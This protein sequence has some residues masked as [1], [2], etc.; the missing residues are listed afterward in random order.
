M[1]TNIEEKKAKESGDITGSICPDLC[2]GTIVPL[3]EGGY[4]CQ[5]CG[6]WVE[7]RV[8]WWRQALDVCQEK[9]CL[10]ALDE[11]LGGTGWR[12]IWRTLKRI[13]LR[14]LH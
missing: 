7:D 14:I 11:I 13:W 12:R 2:G 8:D 9:H 10:E 5:N 4:K 3:K 1:N 6:W